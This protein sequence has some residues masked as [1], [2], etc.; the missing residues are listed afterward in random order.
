M[1][2]NII[3]I[4]LAAGFAAPALAETGVTINR[5][6]SV[7]NV[8]GRAGTP[9]TKPAGVVVYTQ[10]DVNIAGRNPVPSRI[11]KTVI[12]NVRDLDSGFGR[13]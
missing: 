12:S 9:A 5:I 2:R 4:T 3:A 8:Y 10:T 11:G 1:I 13:T 7:T 6:D